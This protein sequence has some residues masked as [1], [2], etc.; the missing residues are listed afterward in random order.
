[1][2][3]HAVNTTGAMNLVNSI[4]GALALML[5]CALLLPTG[6]AAANKGGI[7]PRPITFEPEPLTKLHPKL[8]WIKRDKIRAAWVSADLHKPYGDTDKTQA[9]VLAD[10][11]FNTVIFAMRADNKN[12]SHMPYLAEVMPANIEA[13][14]AVGLAAWVKMSYGTTHQDPYHRYRDPAGKLATKTC[15]PLDLPYL[16]R[17]FGRWAVKFAEAGADGF[18]LDTEM[19]ESD[20][21]DYEGPCVCSYCFRAYLDVFADNGD[22]IYDSTPAAQRGIWLREIGVYGHY[23]RFAVKRTEDFLDSIRARCQAHNDAFILGYASILEH[24]PGNTRGFGTSTVPCVILDESEYTSGPTF[25]MRRNLQYIEQSGLPALYIGGLWINQNR[26]EQLA[27]RGL[28]AALYADG[29]WAWYAWALVTKPDA[30][31]GPETS[32]PYGRWKGTKSRAYWDVLEPMHARLEKLLA[33]DRAAWPAFPL[34]DAVAPVPTGR[35][36][37][38]QGQITLDGSLDDPGWQEASQFEM[39]ID[40]FGKKNGPENTFML[41][42][43]DTAFYF[44]ARCPIPEG[45]VLPE[46][47]R[48]H[49]HPRAWANHGLELFVDPSGAGRRYAQLILSPD[50]DTYESAIDYGHAPGAF[51]FG[52]LDWNPAIEVGVQRTE[53]EFILEIRILFEDA[54]LTRPRHGET[55]G[56]N[57]CRSSSAVQSWSPT[58]GPFHLPGRFG[59]IQ[60]VEDR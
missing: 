41:C 24:L 27:E 1:M 44:A 47:L 19:Y 45:T 23:S 18:I 49:D 35:V 29:W 37:L 16:E 32:N 40:R 46:Q 36:P 55:W 51:Q 21:S 58:Y 3:D 30:T 26:P 52:D 34:L 57:V 13:A 43:D 59:R 54:L 60:F 2:N 42:H 15:C 56:F 28:L 17:H 4:P 31:T 5:A 33:G 20:L 25:T 50:G 11:G 6:A 48:G 22:T 53:A 9:R 8:A 38:R 10:G 14:H 39:A 7:D 12:R